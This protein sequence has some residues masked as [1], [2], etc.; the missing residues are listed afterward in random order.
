[1]L[2]FAVP[3][4]AR[5]ADESV[6]PTCALGTVEKLT[7]AQARASG[8]WQ[9]GYEPR[10]LE[11]PHVWLRF[12]ENSLPHGSNTSLSGEATAFDNIRYVLQFADGRMRVEDVSAQ[13]IARNWMPQTRFAVPLYERWEKP[14]GLY[15]RLDGAIT[16][17]PAMKLSVEATDGLENARLGPLVL[18]GL[19]IG[20]MLLAGLYSAIIFGG[21]HNK[22]AKW[23]LITAGL[24]VIYTISSSSLIFL[25]YPDTTLFQR[26]SLSYIALSVAAASIV[27]FFFS[28]V[29]EKHILPQYR[30]MLTACGW[31]LIG[32]AFLMPTLSHTIP[33]MIRPIYHSLYLPPLIAFILAVISAWRRGSRPV[34]WIALAWAL[35]VGFAVER[36]LRGMDLYQASFELDHAFYYALA[37]MAIVMAFAVSW[38][39]NDLRKERDRAV[40]MGSELNRQALSDGLT[41]LPNRR[42]FEQ[43]HWRD[44]DFL[45]IVDV[46]LFKSVNDDFGHQAG[47]DV[48]RVI[49][50]CLLGDTAN[51]RLIGAWRLGGEEFAVLTA[52][53]DITA[54]AIAL[55]EIRGRISAE[56]AQ[57]VEGVDRPVTL[58]MGLARIAKGKIDA[59][60]READRAMYR[61]K[62]A[63]RD[64]L[65]YE[66][67]ESVLATIFPSRAA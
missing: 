66:N 61:A 47:D 41:G 64:R 34:R 48:L 67:Q 62:S 33:F 38:R 32:N 50:Q 60:Y 25:I 30:S 45:A 7:F 63:G 52:A 31:L 56:I 42:S 54:A 57:M 36:S 35:P 14:S 15:A 4:Q 43:R 20:M 11:K 12:D 59:A 55:N 40:A 23:H 28:F 65:S 58:S 18:F 49:G 6:S 3:S 46:D 13:K 16:T 2:L 44:S 22:F 10:H 53:S 39:V 19:F 51:G 9:C 24:F 27:P 29:S 17:Q 5:A 8:D 26:T 1:M 21:M 37:Y